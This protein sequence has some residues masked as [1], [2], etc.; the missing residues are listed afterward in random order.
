MYRYVKLFVLSSIL[1]VLMLDV[2]CLIGLLVS[3]S[4]RYVMNGMVS[5][6]FC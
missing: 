4:I 5:V 6:V 2:K 1:C 3:D